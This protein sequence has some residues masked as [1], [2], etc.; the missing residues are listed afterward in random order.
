MIIRKIY[1]IRIFCDNKLF[2]KFLFREK[3]DNFQII[4]IIDDMYSN[5]YSNQNYKIEVLINLTTW[6]IIDNN[7]FYKFLRTYDDDSD[8]D[9]DEDN[10]SEKLEITLSNIISDDV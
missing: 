2:F 1:G 8:D 7:T 10:D 5:L 9:S 4:N 3:F 6:I